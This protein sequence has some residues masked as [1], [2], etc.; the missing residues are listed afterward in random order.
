MPPD[1]L[2]WLPDDAIA[3][4]GF[5]AGAGAAAIV[6]AGAAIMPVAGAAMVAAGAG[7]AMPMAGAVI[8]ATG[9]IIGAAAAC[10]A[11]PCPDPEAWPLAAPLD[12]NMPPVDVSG[13]PWPVALPMRFPAA[14]PVALPCAWPAPPR[15]PFAIP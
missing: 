6:F 4:A 9:D 3:G 14:L 7:A 12:C 8:I 10:W 5:A 1:R 11:L 15:A 2:G 13:L